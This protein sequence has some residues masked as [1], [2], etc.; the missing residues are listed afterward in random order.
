M[1]EAKRINV[2]CIHQQHTRALGIHTRLTHIHRH[3]QMTCCSGM[4]GAGGSQQPFGKNARPGIVG[5]THNQG[6]I[7]DLKFVPN[8]RYNYKPGPGGGARMYPDPPR[9][10][11]PRQASNY[12][13]G[14]SQACNCGCS[15]GFVGQIQEDG[16]TIK[17]V[18]TGTPVCCGGRDSPARV[19]G[20][21]ELRRPYKFYDN[22]RRTPN[23]RQS[24]ARWPCSVPRW[25]GAAPSEH[26][27]AAH[28]DG[29]FWVAGDR[30]GEYKY[31]DC[32][33]CY[34]SSDNDEECVDRDA[35]WCDECARRGHYCPEE[36][37]ANQER[38]PSPRQTS[39]LPAPSPSSTTWVAPDTPTSD[40]AH[41]VWVTVCEKPCCC[42]Q[43]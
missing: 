29:S 35:C 20:K 5:S 14:K 7:A 17:H 40:N 4:P 31:T 11:F 3:T 8:E 30:H 16:V 1:E 38:P 18:Y 6:G 32:T 9:N 12:W 42:C 39:N 24:V 22:V 37:T 23:G 26:R 19:E 27:T 15:S 34:D 41:C 36:E 21:R 13:S 43:R 10:S 33:P 28:R 25:E 2:C